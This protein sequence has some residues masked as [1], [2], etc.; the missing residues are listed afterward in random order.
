VG[1]W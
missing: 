1:H